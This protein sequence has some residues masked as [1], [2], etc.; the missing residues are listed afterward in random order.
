MM[1]SISAIV[2]D[3]R[4][5]YDS[6]NASAAVARTAKRARERADLT[7]VDVSDPHNHDQRDV[8]DAY[9]GLLV[10]TQ[11]PFEQQIDRLDDV[12][13]RDGIF[14]GEIDGERTVLVGEEALDVVE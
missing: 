8:I 5:I 13:P 7:V 4:F 6:K 12:D 9:R 3:Q 11:G 14:V 1:E 2:D 10:G